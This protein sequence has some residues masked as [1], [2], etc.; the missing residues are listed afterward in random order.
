VDSSDVEV[1]NLV[2]ESTWLDP[3][4]LRLRG[5]QRDNLSELILLLESRQGLSQAV[6][7][8]LL[9]RRSLI[10]EPVESM[11]RLVAE[12]DAQSPKQ[13]RESVLAILGRIVGQWNRANSLQLPLPEFPI[14]M[15]KPVPPFTPKRWAGLAKY[16]IWTDAVLQDLVRSASRQ[17][18]GTSATSAAEPVQEDIA[19]CVARVLVSAVLW[20]GLLCR[21][22]LE[23]LYSS[24]SR[25][26]EISECAHDRVYVTW[27]D[28]ARNCRRWMPDAITTLLM[29]RLK[30][31]HQTQVAALAAEH[32][33]EC[34]VLRYF[35][36]VLP[37]SPS[38][39]NSL[40][41]FIDSSLLHFEL[42]LPRHLTEYA[43]GKLPSASPN[44]RTWA[45]MV[46]SKPLV[47]KTTNIAETV[48]EEAD[49]ED[50]DAD[51]EGLDDKDD[52]WVPEFRQLLGS[53]DSAL[54]PLK[55]RK[56]IKMRLQNS[57]I[58]DVCR[59]FL[60]FAYDLLFEHK[61]GQLKTVRDSVIPIAIKLP[62]AVDLKKIGEIPPET[63]ASAYSLLLEDACTPSQRH[64]LRGYLRT[65]HDWLVRTGRSQRLDEAEVFG[66]GRQTQ[67]VDAS[68]IMEDEYI[69]ARDSLV[70]WSMK[71]DEEADLGKDLRQI[72]GL[73]LILGYRTGLRK[74]EVLKSP[75][76]AVMVEPPAELLVQPWCER[77]LKTPNAVRKISLYAL[78]DRPETKENEK[79]PGEKV[80]PGD[81]EKNELRLL[82]TW[83]KRRLLQ[84][85]RTANPSPY[86]FF[87][88][89]LNRRFIPEGRIF[90]LIHETLREYTDDKTVHFHTCRKS[91][92]GTWLAFALLRPPNVPLPKWLKT[93]PL[94]EARIEQV[95]RLHRNLYLN[96]FATRRH[97]FAT[98][99]NLGHSS[100]GVSVQNYLELQGDLL[101]LWLDSVRPDLTASQVSAITGLSLRE[102]Y[103]LLSDPDQPQRK[104]YSKETLYR[105]LWS[106]I[107]R[108]WKKF[109]GRTS[110]STPS[111][112]DFESDE[113]LSI[114][115]KF[116]EGCPFELV[117]IQELLSAHSQGASN[118]D[119]PLRWGYPDS[120]INALLAIAGK[121]AELT[122]VED[123]TQL[124]H[125]RPTYVHS[126]RN[127]TS[128][129]KSVCPII[130]WTERDVAI[131]TQLGPKIF[132]SFQDRRAELLPIAQHWL[133]SRRDE[134]QGLEF[135]M[136]EQ[137][138]A[139]QYADFL[140]ELKELRGK[141][142]MRYF[143]SE[144][145][146]NN[147][148]EFLPSPLWRRRKPAR[149]PSPAK[150]ATNSIGIKV[151]LGAA[152]KR[153]SGASQTSTY[154]WRYLMLLV[155]LWA[156][157]WETTSP[158]NQGAHSRPEKLPQSE[159]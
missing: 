131:V 36:L 141:Y 65:W 47:L 39:P 11:R 100:P 153:K 66:R 32:R 106:H 92:A 126:F 35:G 15:P 7:D 145:S 61:N 146:V 88:P 31:E 3:D 124:Q 117:E 57:R 73:I 37:D 70:D 136:Q 48:S 143:G 94:Q 62:A 111:T 96:D 20:G 42:R 74:S 84:N 122:V 134:R 28:E 89:A 1:S 119:L 112:S 108:K 43:A 69:K 120:F 154:G 13:S 71:F 135:S 80:G 67:T 18:R 129:K 49:S 45:R 41:K 149:P 132:K 75:L 110:T 142:S 144:E 97:L 54:T 27:F 121:A 81:S 9:G 68:L 158:S 51:R 85:S 86:L 82:R 34:I 21:K 38:I 44:P 46:R 26:P 14:R 6:A 113:P 137:N 33:M 4:N 109:N 91:G 155:S 114:H 53:G 148:K 115:E 19:I 95:A 52:D 147:W 12:V 87:T 159:T 118:E 128:G 105:N 123:T 101:G 60:S 22:N 77:R 156:L 98:A 102:A 56:A 58:D 157:A 130:P 30:P 76:N 17:E 138:L 93:W 25:W 140:N 10:S 151:L 55:A 24:L 64:K 40:F 29:M 72:A 133:E 8:C 99:R 78:L 2:A 104:R 83:V 116:L 79:T 152:D 139:K 59:L 23:L 107:S 16:R 5:K 63:L 90:P 127:S 150:A 125:R 50:S 103:N